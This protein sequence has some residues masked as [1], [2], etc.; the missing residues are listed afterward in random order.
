MIE[1][2]HKIV[3]CLEEGIPAVIATVVESEGS[4]PRKAGSKM[5]I[6]RDGHITGTIGGGKMEKKV[7]EEAI[8]LMGTGETRVLQ[9]QLTD[10][11]V[12]ICGGA[13]KIFLEDLH[14]RPSLVII[15]GGHIAHYLAGFAKAVGFRVTVIDDRRDFL[16]EDRFPGIDRVYL[17][18]YRRIPD[19]YREGKNR[20][21]VIMT[22]GHDIDRTCLKAFL[23]RELRY[24]GMV[25]SRKKIARIFDQLRNEG[26]NEA[27]LAAVRT[28]VGLN[29]GGDTPG[30]IALSIAAELLAEHH[31]VRK[32]APIS[33]LKGNE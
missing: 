16:T 24:V 18:D 7:M 28:P 5:C 21:T 10:E 22:R 13:T 26:V 8:A 29:L 1:V 19:K 11:S 12:G 31:D 32:I 20:Y 14:H 23:G 17:P 25:G 15:G 2:Y 33:R 27:H 3:Q 30:E 9:F 6:L 4:S